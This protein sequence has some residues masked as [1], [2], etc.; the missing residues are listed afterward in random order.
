MY[1]KFIIYLLLFSIYPIG[2]YA[3]LQQAYYNIRP[4][5]NLES[6]PDK[7][8][9]QIIQDHDG[10]M[11]FATNNGLCRYDGY[12]FKIYKSSNQSPDLLQ[13]NIVNAI[14]EDTDHNLWI[15]TERGLHVLDRSTDKI[16]PISNDSLPNSFI[17]TLLVSRD[18]TL[19]IGTQVGLLKYNRKNG[20][21]TQY[22]NRPN[23]KTSIG[24]NS[25]QALLEDPSGDI[26]VGTF[27]N[28]ICRLDIKR[29]RF[30]QYPEITALNRTNYLLQDADKNIWICNWGDGV[31]RMDNHDAPD[32]TRYLQFESE[33]GY[34]CIFKCLQQL[35]DGTILAGT[36]Q[37][38]YQIE[39]SGRLIPQNTNIHPVFTSNEDIND[40]FVD[41]KGNIWIGTTNSG[42]YIAYQ[43]KKPFDNHPI[44]SNLPPF[45]KL[46]VNALYEWDENTLLLGMDKISFSFYDKTKKENTGYKEIPR[47]NKLF[48]QW[49][50][51]LQFIFKHPS[52]NE[53]WFGTQF[54]GL[55]IC[56]L[57]GGKI[58]SCRYHV[59]H[60]GGTSIGACI[61][62][63]ISDKDG[64]IWIGSDE[65]VNVITS[66][67]DTLSYST[68][69]RI[70]CICQ[71]HTGTVWLGTYFDGIYCFGANQDIHKLSFK[72]YNSKNKL[73]NADEIMCIY[74]DKEQNLWIG[75]KGYGLQIYNRKEDC[76]EPISNTQE[77]PGDIIF[78]MT[79]TDGTLILGTNKGLVLY[80]SHTH[81][82]TI[83]DDKDGMLDKSCLKNAMFNNGKGKIYYGTSNG[84]FVFQPD[85]IDLDTTREKTVISDFLIF[86]KPF[87]E[88][89][90]DKKIR[91]AGH[92][93]P[94][95]SKHITLS[96]SDNNIGIEF[97]ALSYVHPEKKRYAY[98]LEGFDT[99]WIHTD[100]TGRTAF[101]TNLPAGEYR[102]IAK[103]LND[104]QAENP[105]GQAEILI[106]VL[107][108]FYLTNWSFACYALLLI[109]IG[110]AILRFQR[111][112]YKLKE[113]VKIEQIERSKSEELHRSKFRFF[114]NISHE[115]LTP[116]SII[117]C[118]IE[119][120]K[121]MY[122]INGPILKTAESNVIRLNRLIEE[123]LDFQKSE[124]NKLKLNI[125]Y[126]DI[127]TF[128]HKTC[129]E[130][131]SLLASNKNITLGIH[132]D[133]EHI[134]AWFDTDKTDK[135]LYNLLSN[136][137]KFSPTDGNG[138][139]EVCL[140]AKEKESEFQYK[141]LI[142]KVRNTGKGIAADKLPHIF[143]R[144]Y[145]NSF[146]QSGSKGNGI[147]L[148]LTKSLVELHGG[149]ISASS[150]PGEWT[151][152]TICLP[153]SKANYEEEQI[154]GP[155][156][157][158]Q[159]ADNRP[160]TP[161]IMP[162][163]NEKPEG[164]PTGQSSLLIIEDDEDLRNSLR[165]LLGGKYRTAIATNGEEGLSSAKKTKP[166]LIISD[167]M[168]PVMDGFELCKHL[169]GNP[170]TSCIPIILLTAKI[171]SKDQL[172]GLNCGADAYVTKPF[173]I[174]LLEAQ[175]E[176][177]LSNRKKMV[178]KIHSNPLTRKIELNVSSY[179]ERFLQEAVDTVKENMED[180]EFDVKRFCEAMQVSN[181]ML[182]RKLKSLT[183]LSPNEFIR[184]IRFDVAKE[185]IRQRKGNISDI[186]YR[187]GFK[188]ARYFSSSFKKEF[189]MTPGEYLEKGDPQP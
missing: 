172:E 47:Y 178:D 68:Y 182:Y 143:S 90:E 66:G 125:S 103:S 186:A 120:I 97:A 28:G 80:N 81:Q 16:I 133:P 69:N 41:H 9:N 38:L 60:L 76:F 171:N 170:E 23:D 126:G 159:A 61:N 45:Q 189:N 119:E 121:R 156:P 17:H 129:R 105:D 136:A 39:P 123:I 8:I 179:E 92:V 164:D 6:L 14:A 36:N 88:L 67:N 5:N 109:A 184:N 79:E 142:I 124:N 87:D 50:G 65:G 183:G 140:Q 77:I 132:S 167:V 49:P 20:S 148:A 32:S 138:K 152:F 122:A 10:Y 11:W 141:T 107:P 21:F 134:A 71:D 37:G 176:A 43:E 166:D 114:T 48:D 27:D 181:S 162:G 106:K 33:T 29:Q 146:K 64:N 113:A 99:E 95:H 139:I 4:V 52:K 63:I 180:P 187:V 7:Q 91:L 84:F 26:W 149:T 185:L 74:E 46:K 144:F 82:S 2:L 83:L 35:P 70:Q 85:L 94:L 98:K 53:L 102:F 72:T 93:H 157:E 135:V 168:M 40:L 54:G 127:S 104:G 110:Y 96:S 13:S 19:W 59:H 115:F 57:E 147:G 137:V 31:S 58:T 75:T 89:D 18:S 128:I 155:A 100:A 34:E 12:R 174:T 145:E 86:H 111:F 158:Q 3:N 161:A 169:K 78:N 163:P 24:G 160:D 112:R 118:S 173:N 154:S 177:I 150:V 153:I 73:L 151:E 30:V 165:H 55:I 15:G 1:N 25:I 130:N 116:L 62:S 56:Q 42:A 108:P 131:F 175:I 44:L 101:Y 22:K 51:N 117:S 188:D